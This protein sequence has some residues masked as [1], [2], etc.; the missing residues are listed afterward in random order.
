MRRGR[1]R[2]A[3]RPREAGIHDRPEALSVAAATPRCLQAIPLARLTGVTRASG[4][5]SRRNECA[6]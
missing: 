5:V 1:R 6:L 4:I 3:D 2:K